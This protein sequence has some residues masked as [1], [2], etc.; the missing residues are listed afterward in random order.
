MYWSQPIPCRNDR[1]RIL[2][3]I[4]FGTRKIECVLLMHLAGGAFV[5]YQK[6]SE[7]KK[8]DVYSMK[9][10]IITQLLTLICSWRPPPW[11]VCTHLLS[12]DAGAFSS[13]Q[14]LDSARPN[15]R[16]RSLGYRFT[17]SN[18]FELPPPKWIIS[19]YIYI[20]E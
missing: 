3:A 12:G 6:L 14:W 9:E 7:E 2:Y 1:R 20:Y 17:S 10:S 16:L 11:E 8:A 18:S 15:I 13:I 5:M 19:T 4:C